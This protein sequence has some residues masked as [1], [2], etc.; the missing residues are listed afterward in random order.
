MKKSD[1]A[2]ALK[3]AIKAVGEKAIVH[4]ARFLSGVITK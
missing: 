2:A 3:A 1:H 4:T